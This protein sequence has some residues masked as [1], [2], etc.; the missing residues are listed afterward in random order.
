[1]ENCHMKNHLDLSLVNNIL[2][3]LRKKISF[4]SKS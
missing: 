4:L 1:M 2:E 3:I